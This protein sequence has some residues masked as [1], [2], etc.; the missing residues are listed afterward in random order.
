MLAIRLSRVGT[1]KRPCYRV[2]VIDSRAPRDGRFVELLGYYH[3]RVDPEVLKV[4]YDRVSYWTSKGARLSDTVR[5]LL[6]RHPASPPEAAASETV[7][8]VVTPPVAAADTLADT[9]GNETQGTT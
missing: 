9:V 3:P 6:A 4:D 8:P 5:S 1:K 7:S 2:V